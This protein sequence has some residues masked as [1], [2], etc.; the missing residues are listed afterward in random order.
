MAEG[1]S[2]FLLL[3]SV[4]NNNSSGLSERLR[5]FSSWSRLPS[6]NKKP[7]DFLS[8]LDHDYGYSFQDILLS[9]RS[10]MLLM[11]KGHR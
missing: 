6:K 11:P 7:F 9:V 3:A 4:K 1:Q 8:G 10:H 5:G 2:I